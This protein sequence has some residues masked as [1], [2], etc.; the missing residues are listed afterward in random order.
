M[1]PITP[2][3]ALASRKVPDE[4]ISVFNKLIINNADIND[5]EAIVYQDEAILEILKLMPEIK[6]Q[7]IF[8]KH[9]L[10]VEPL[11]QNAGWIV[12]YY[13]ETIGSY[14]KSYYSFRPKND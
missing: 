14:D 13:K 7:D 6:R 12:R 4:V 2:I 3:E 1:K 8:D 9:W 5:E 11:Y 10:D